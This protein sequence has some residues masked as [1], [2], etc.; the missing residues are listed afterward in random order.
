MADNEKKPVINVVPAIL[1][2]AAALIAALTTVYV[3]LRND[4]RDEPAPPAVVAGATPDKPE[5]AKPSQPQTIQLQLQRIAVQQD[6]AV[7]NADWRFA[8]EADGQPLFAFE[9]DAMTSEGGR[10]IVVAA[11]D[12]DANA[13]IELAPGRPVAITIKG[14]RGSWFKKADEPLVVG[15]GW[16]TSTGALAPITVKAQEEKDGAFTFYLSA[17][18][19]QE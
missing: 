10:N 5:P 16:L 2:G 7:G 11:N 1:T 6:G 14:W 9:Q 8:V 17:S 4:L 13:E 12:R 15:Q 18:A 3:N 19:E